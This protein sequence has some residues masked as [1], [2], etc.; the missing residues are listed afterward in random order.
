MN[1][2]LDIDFDGDRHCVLRHAGQAV[3]VLDHHDGVGDG[4]AVLR[5]LRGLGEVGTVV[6]EDDA[7]AAAVLGV[8]AGRD[9]GCYPFGCE[10]LQG[11]YAQRL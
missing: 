5:F 7:R 1:L 10:E 6:V 9:D 4:D 11:L 2:G 8:A 3:V